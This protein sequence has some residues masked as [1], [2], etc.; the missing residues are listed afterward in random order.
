MSVT[1]NHM[2]CKRFYLRGKRTDKSD[3]EKVSPNM[4]V[5]ELMRI[6]FGPNST[7]DRCV[8]LE[9]NVVLCFVFIRAIVL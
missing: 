9:I 4:T 1:D 5:Y 7:T 8:E 6:S 2:T 3:F